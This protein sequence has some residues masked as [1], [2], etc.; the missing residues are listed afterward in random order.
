MKQ[1]IVLSLTVSLVVVGL[2]FLTPSAKEAFEKGSV[3]FVTHGSTPAPVEY[4]DSTFAQSSNFALTELISRF[5]NASDEPVTAIKVKWIIHDQSGTRRT[6]TVT[7]DAMPFGDEPSMG[8]RP[9]E[10][11]SIIEVR[12]EATIGLS[13]AIDHIEVGLDF[14]ETRGQRQSGIEWPTYGE[15]WPNKL[16]E[17]WQAMAEKRRLIAT[18]RSFLVLEADKKGPGWAE[19]VLQMERD[20]RGRVVPQNCNDC[21]Q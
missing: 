5:R 9:F 11:G 14:V 8:G 21:D 17:S 1:W 16:N 2:N 12:G 7:I 10:P 13:A 3:H 15:V 4:L 18:F 20:R 6:A 19:E